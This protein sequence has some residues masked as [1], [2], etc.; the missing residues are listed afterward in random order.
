M[1]LDDVDR[2]CI[3]QEYVGIE[4]SVE[5]N[6]KIFHD[7]KQT[8]SYDDY[9]K[10]I[11]EE[12]SDTEEFRP[13]VLVDDLLNSS[14]QVYHDDTLI[15]KIEPRGDK[16]QFMSYEGIGDVEY[17]VIDNSVSSDTPTDQVVEKYQQFDR[18]VIDGEYLLDK[19]RKNSI[20]DLYLRMIR[21]H[22]G[23]STKLQCE[24]VLE[25]ETTS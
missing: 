16:F 1:K 24:V 9:V 21:N 23:I 11:K 6:I 17:P 15:G 7:Y 13:I 5:R 4:N 3:D 8:H 2:W 25:E 10:L 19:S 14:T 12:H 20:D 22:Y 18:Y